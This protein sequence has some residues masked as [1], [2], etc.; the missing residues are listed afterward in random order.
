VG[1][2]KFLIDAIISMLKKY[3]NTLNNNN[4]INITAITEIIIPEVLS[5]PDELFVP[6][7]ENE[8]VAFEESPKE[9]KTII[10][11]NTTM[12]SII[13]AVGFINKLLI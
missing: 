5:N 4:I 3:C 11:I 10:Y 7:V 2:N 12:T 6:T 13:K 9:T 8:L 1:L